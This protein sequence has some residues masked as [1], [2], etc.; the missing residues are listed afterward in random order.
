MIANDSKSY[1]GYLNKFIDDTYILLIIVILVKNL[2]ML[3]ILLYIT[4]LNRVIKLLS[5][6][7]VIDSYWISKYE[8]ILAKITQKKWSKEIFVIHSVL[9]SNP[10]MHEIKDLLRE[11]IIG[12]F[13]K[14]VLLS[15]F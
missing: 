15:Q 10:W 5:L 11:K 4:N 2:F 14:K 1:L 9:T 7:L 6:K 13:S 12:S 8:N 3:I